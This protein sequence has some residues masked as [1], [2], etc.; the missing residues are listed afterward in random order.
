MIT[1]EEVVERVAQIDSIADDFE[2]AHSEED[3]LYRDVLYAIVAGSPYPQQ[4]A[5]EALNS[6]QIHFQR[7]CA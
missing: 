2:A 5:T 1:P 7:Y 6:R 3:R 4:L